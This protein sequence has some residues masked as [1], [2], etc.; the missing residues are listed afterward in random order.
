MS[1][2]LDAGKSLA[3]LIL[4]KLPES[5]R[6]NAR[7]AFTAPEAADALT[8]LGDSALA[9]TDYSRSMDE[10]KVKEDTLAADYNKLNTWFAEKKTDLDAYDKIKKGGTP[11]P[12]DPN[13]PPALDPTK[14]ITVESFGKE[15]NLQQRQAADYLALQNVLTLK[16]YDDFKEI[17]DT[18]DLLADANLGK[19]KKD[20][21]VYGL[22]DAYHTKFSDRL[23]KRDQDAETTRINKLVEDRLVEE[24]R[25]S[26]AQ[27][28]PIK[29]APS[30]LDLLEP[31]APTIDP[32]AHTAAAAADEYARL[33]SARG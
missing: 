7:A 33:Q 28:F 3:D 5:L 16:H 32:T 11:P 13:A 8:L 9:R 10:I 6:E 4:A 29:G 20:G 30:P 21:G 15:M 22:I 2:A 27:A 12:T 17:L 24:R 14:F 1:K 31:G 25:K 26:P 23:T 18:R 19:Q